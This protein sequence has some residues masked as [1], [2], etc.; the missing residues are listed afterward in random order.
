[1]N[2]DDE[3]REKMIQAIGWCWAEACE[4]TARG[5]NICQ[6]E[7]PEILDRAQHDFEE[8]AFADPILSPGPSGFRKMT[9]SSEKHRC[10][11]E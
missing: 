2:T 4:R 1:M 8:L 6:T 3:I 10:K 5:E 7:V 11:H 9:A